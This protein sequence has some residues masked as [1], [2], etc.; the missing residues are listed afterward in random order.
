MLY[1][2]RQNVNLDR[3]YGED[4]L[5]AFTKT[6]EMVFYVESSEAYAGNGSFFGNMGFD[7][8]DQSTLILS[9]DVFKEI[10][11]DSPDNV[12][13][14]FDD[15]G[16]SNGDLIY[17]P[18][19]GRIFE[20][21]DCKNYK[22][23]YQLGK[24]YTY[25]I[26][27]EFWD[28]SNE[29]LKTNLPE[30]DKKFDDVITKKYEIKLLDVPVTSFIVGEQVYIGDILVTSEFIGTVESYTASTKKIIVSSA[31]GEPV[32]GQNLI[33]DDSGAI[34]GIVS[35]ITHNFAN[36]LKDNVPLETE[37]GAS[38]LKEAEDDDFGY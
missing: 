20:I 23:F 17:W 3:I 4:V 34:A 26:T 22:M 27:I 30:I 13:G 12:N 15:T 8:Q 14:K 21:V 33:G 25:E 24:L 38:I 31:Y 9:R 37:G 11:I 29:K 35:F 32:N 10:V 2:P 5:S 1:I 6:Y 18:A 19:T 7:I 28:Y 36:E 16:P